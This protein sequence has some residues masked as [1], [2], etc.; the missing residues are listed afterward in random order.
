MYVRR[1][2][3]TT[4][5]EEIELKRP[6]WIEPAVAIGAPRFHDDP[7]LD[8]ILRRRVDDPLAAA[9]F[10]DPRPRPA[11]DPLELP[12]MCEAVERIARALRRNEPIGIFGDYD[13]DGVTSAALL[14][15][16]LR[17][18]SKGAQPASV[19]LP[20][21]REGYG[22]SVAGVDDLAAAGAKLLIAVDCGSKD[23]VAVERAGELGVEVVILDHHR[24]IEA[25][26]AMA[27]FA[28]AQLHD[29]IP[30]R[31]V[32]AAGLAYLLA[33]ALAQQGFDTGGGPGLEPTPLLDLAMIGLIGDVS[34][35][36]GVNRS[37]VRDGLRQL[38]QAPRPGL[39]AMGEVA[40]I[41]MRK[42]T[43]RDVAFL[44]SPRLNAPGRLDDPRPAY[45]L[46][47]TSEPSKAAKLAHVTELANQRRRT[48]QENVLQEIEASL[49]IEP[50]RLEQRVLVFSGIEWEAGVVGLA[51]SKLADRF[52]R[53]VIVMTLAD[54]I[55]HGSARSVPGF[56]ITAAL[57]ECRDL[58][59]R[60]GG[61][62]RAAGLALQE[63]MI[64]DLDAA[65]QEAAVQSAAPPPGPPRLEIDADIEPERL[66][67]E[68]A[69][70]LQLLAPFG[71]GN[72]MPILRVLGA[73]LRSYRVM[74]RERQHLKLH[75][76]SGGRNVEAILW[77]G[78][79][80]SRE[81]LGVRAVDVVGDVETNE[82]NGTSRVQMR[83]ADFREASW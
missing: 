28:S 75:L 58:L 79:S 20:L 80:R 61:H 39:S 82:W 5:P 6:V 17:A 41:D 25:P 37:L 15:L 68:T 74:G 36:T 7:L 73:P 60:H 21:R 63:V 71:E 19:R 11:P 67:L 51:A 29:D 40:R 56:D 52:D 38:R 49:A 8:A 66:N 32:S 1:E 26:P 78:A 54:G 81:L 43:S 31:I 77:N 48:L 47:I 57:S 55:A 22:L 27:I 69:R 64:T 42:V 50:G 14:T 59:L 65:L 46:L 18:A 9:D 34:P 44:I 13:T 72:P 70:L 2:R 16:A 62:E 4:L 35:L 83:I 12:G 33:T 10:L 45:E 3:R 30:L 76:G 24:V 23:H 53:P